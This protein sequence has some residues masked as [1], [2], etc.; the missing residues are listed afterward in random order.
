MADKAPA[1]L[2]VKNW[3]EF[4]HYKKRSPP[5]IRL[6]RGLLDNEDYW[7]LPLDS[8]A[9]AP[10]VWLLASESEDG[11]VS[12]DPERIAYRLRMTRDAVVS[13]VQPLIDRGFL[14][15]S[16]LV[17]SITL[18]PRAQDV[19]P[20]QRRDRAESEADQ[21]QRER[22][23][24]GPS[25]DRPDKAKGGLP[26][27]I[28]GDRDRRAREIQRLAREMSAMD[29][30]LAPLQGR[31][32]PRDAA[33]FI[34]DAK[35][36]DRDSARGSLNPADWSDKRLVNAHMDMQQNH[37]TLRKQLDVARAKRAS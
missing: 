1:R 24:A 13:A 4:Q 16:L 18:A 21:S 34:A 36:T 14:I 6:Y 27:E 35:T 12:A 15:G 30:E 8:R 26:P 22:Q 17:A 28:V 37:A 19:S 29:L 33:A 20:E 3:K 9:L 31:T 11:S 5:W 23:S 7:M 10:C 32:E 25:A 2:R